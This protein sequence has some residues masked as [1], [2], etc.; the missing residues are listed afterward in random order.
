M[1][2]FNNFQKFLRRA[3]CLRGLALIDLRQTRK[4]SAD[5]LWG[6]EHSVLAQ[7]GLYISTWAGIERMLNEFIVQYHPHRTA[8]LRA[9][10]PSD[11]GNKITYLD[12]VSDDTRLPEHLRAG[13]K[14]W[15]ARLSR[16]KEYRHFMVH[17]IGH[18]KRLRGRFEWS[19]QKLHLKGSKAELVEETFDNEEIQKR[20][21]EISDLSHSIAK[22]LTP[23]LHPTHQTSSTNRP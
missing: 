5:S 15:V 22:L 18:H 20:S 9:D 7:I 6:Y 10:L 3:K 16:Q 1:P 4:H 12:S 11:L 13:L 23:F 2:K 19:F 14:E 8:N 17:G 21:K